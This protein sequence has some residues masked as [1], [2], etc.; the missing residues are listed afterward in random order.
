MAEAEATT[1]LANDVNFLNH[2]I[3]KLPTGAASL[4]VGTLA[5]GLTNDEG[6]QK[7]ADDALKVFKY[8]QSSMDA[9]CWVDGQFPG[10]GWSRKVDNQ[11]SQ[12]RS[13]LEQ[14]QTIALKGV[15]YVNEFKGFASQ[16]FDSP[17]DI[18]TARWF[19]RD[20]PDRGLGELTQKMSQD[21]L[22]LSS[23]VKTVKDEFFKFAKQNGVSY[24]PQQENLLR[25]IESFQDKIAVEQ[26]EATTAQKALNKIL[27]G[28]TMAG[29][30]FE[31]ISTFSQS[32]TLVREAVELL[33]KH[34][35]AAT[36]L[37]RENDEIIRAAGLGDLTRGIWSP[38]LTIYVAL[39]VLS[40]DMV[41]IIS[42]VSNFANLWAAAHSDFLEFQ[43]WVKNDYDDDSKILLE[44]KIKALISTTNVFAA[45]MERFARVLQAGM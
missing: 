5:T 40:N 13:A 25:Q 10:W 30:I 42:R 1:L 22:D 34:T 21:F 12:Y 4:T 20:P 19:E 14:A 43:Y 36:A 17:G 32:N 15:D 2:V 33:E 23:E 35:R 37:R 26:S 38:G 44:L 18:R 39:S 45:D 16:I 8:F 11:R 31:T 6:A 29:S 9:L 27:T 24:D 28:L 7:I 41:D 3:G